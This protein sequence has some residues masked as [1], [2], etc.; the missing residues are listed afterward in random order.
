M[1]QRLDQLVHVLIDRLCRHK[2]LLHF[3]VLAQ[4]QRADI[5]ELQRQTLFR[6]DEESFLDNSTEAQRADGGTKQTNGFFDIDGDLAVL[7]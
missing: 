1:N 3:F 2:P 6:V 5:A 4:A 7:I